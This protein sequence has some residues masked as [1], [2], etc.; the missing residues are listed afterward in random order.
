MKLQLLYFASLREALGIERETVETDV[1][2]IGELRVW[3]CARGGAYAQA[4]AK[5]LL[6]R[7]SGVN[8]LR[9]FTL[10]NPARL[11]QNMKEANLKRKLVLKKGD[12][13]LRVIPQ[14]QNNNQSDYRAVLSD[15]GV[16]S[17]CDAPAYAGNRKIFRAFRYFQAR[18]EE[19]VNGGSDRLASIMAFLD[20]V[21]QA[22][23]VKIEVASHADA[24]TLFESLNNRGMPLT[25]IDLIKKS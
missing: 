21:S 20:K 18:I 19:M 22:C 8:T 11:A 9:E 4:A 15:V 1:R 17:Q 24:Y 6:L 14:I 25:A 12:D 10:R 2:T 23:L 3:L 5:A 13:Q 7:A 16:I